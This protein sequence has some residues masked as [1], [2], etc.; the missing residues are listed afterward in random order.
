MHA[1]HVHEA[2]P[3]GSAAIEV[4]DSGVQGRRRRPVALRMRGG[5]QRW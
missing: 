3:W 5:Q 1:T 4:H 2:D